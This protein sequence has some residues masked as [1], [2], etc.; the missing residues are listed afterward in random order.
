MNRMFILALS[1][2]LCSFGCGP[3][4]TPASA[5]GE[6]PSAGSDTVNLSKFEKKLTD[7]TI[8]N[9]E[10]SDGGG[11]QFLYNELNFKAD[12]T[13]KAAGVVKANFEEFPCTESGTWSVSS[14]NSANS[15]TLEWTLKDTDCISREPGLTLRTLIEFSGGDYKISFR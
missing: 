14:E 2:L 10:P 12:K 9:W 4:K 3:K 6:T 15:G 1:G 5:A 13:W 8:T 11:A 7:T